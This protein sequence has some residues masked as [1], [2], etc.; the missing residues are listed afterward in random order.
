MS[1]FSYVGQVVCSSFDFNLNEEFSFPGN[2][3]HAMEIT[4]VLRGARTKQIT[5][6]ETPNARVRQSAAAPRK[7]PCANEDL[8]C[9]ALRAI[10]VHLVF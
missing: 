8:N 6:R 5:G 2:V 10:K 1:H 9:L 4:A 3:Q 7:G